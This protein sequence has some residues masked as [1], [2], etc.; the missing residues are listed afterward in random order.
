MYLCKLYFP[1]GFHISNGSR[2]YSQTSTRLYSDTLFSALFVTMLT[3]DKS[4][5]FETLSTQLVIS[6]A[7]PYSGSSLFFPIPK[8]GENLWHNKPKDSTNQ[9]KTKKIEYIEKQFL[10]DCLAKGQIEYDENQFDIV[11][12]HL[13]SKN[14][15]EIQLSKRE[16]VTRIQKGVNADEPRPFQFDKYRFG[17]DSGLFFLAD[18]S[19]ELLPKLK[20]ALALLG[21]NGI[22]S[23]RSIGVGVF[24]SCVEPFTEFEKFTKVDKSIK[25]SY[26]LS[27]WKPKQ[28]EYNLLNQ[29]SHYTLLNRGGWVASKGNT[30]IK[31]LSKKMVYFVEDGSVISQKP[32]GEIV[33]VTPEGIQ[34]G[35]KVLRNG[36]AL[37]LNINLKSDEK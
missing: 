36:I 3:L 9:K 10:I 37:S 18:I 19:D 1:N 27:L 23:D 4:T 17:D 26:L 29:D 22:G 6:S 13:V 20:A 8:L 2:D 14:A 7:F 34:L 33:D 15:Q 11:G 24:E 5:E 32:I 31:P 16:V 12:K 25:Y 35:H 28:S 21:E 30:N